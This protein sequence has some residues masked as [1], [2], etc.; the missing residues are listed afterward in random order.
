MDRMSHEWGALTSLDLLSTNALQAIV[1]DVLLATASRHAIIAMFNEDE[2]CLEVTH[3]AGQR[4]SHALGQR[5]AIDDSFG[6]VSYVAATGKTFVTGDVTLEPKYRKLFENTVSEAAAPIRDRFGRIVGVINVESD[7]RDAFGDIER[8]TCRTFAKFAAVVLELESRQSRENALIKVGQALASALTEESLIS[9]VVYV[10]SEMLHFQAASIFVKDSAS[11]QF[12]LRGSTSRLKSKVGEIQYA[13]GEGCTGWVCEHGEPIML[14][15]PQKDSRWRGLYLEFPGDEI[16]AFLCV[17]ILINGKSEGA[18]RILRRKADNRF[19]EN[20][21]TEDDLALMEAIAGQ[22]A[23]GLQNI[24]SVERM[25]KS[26]R[27][28]A[29]GELSAKSSHMIG[30]R[31]FALKGD[32]NELRYQLKNH[33]N[34]S[35]TLMEIA[36]S[37]DVNV[38]RIE[39]I[40]QDFRDFLSATQLNLS[41]VNLNDIVRETATEVFPRRSK[42]KLNLTLEESLPMLPL[43]DKRLRR[44]ISELIENSLPYAGASESNKVL[45]ISTRLAKTGPNDKNWAEIEVSDRGPGIAQE[46]KTR[47]FEPFYT[48]RVKGMGLGLSIVKGI[49]EAHGGTIAEDGEPGIGATF[50]IRLPI[51]ERP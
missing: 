23:S 16:A 43:D 12:V 39:E 40:L 41:W 33:P 2:G 49:V 50:V 10:A 45:N 47:I 31:V 44:A 21:F 35:Q 24:R 15:N 13:K 36:K 11:H 9:M 37:L 51:A 30:N 34:S 32:V 7:Q 26:E 17:P 28:V 3:V 27:M 46:D 42:V 25:L 1:D 20:R 6:I 29:W 18:I 4:G 8:E 38:S 19:L 22:V 5:L 14:Q 48:G